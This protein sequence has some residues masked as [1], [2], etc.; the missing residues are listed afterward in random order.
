MKLFRPTTNDQ[1]ANALAHFFPS[2]CAWAAKNDKDANFRKFIEALAFEFKRVHDGMNDLSCDY[3]INMTTE[4]IDNWESAVGIPDHCFSKDVPIERRRLQV[5]VKFAKMN[6]QTA[7]DFARL[8]QLL[9]FTVTVKSGGDVGIFPLCF[10][11]VFFPDPTEARFTLILCLDKTSN[12]F[13]LD[14]PIQFSDSFSS[15]IVCILNVIKPA[16]VKLLVLFNC[17]TFCHHCFCQHCAP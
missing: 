10:P 11:I 6:V 2:G 3:D 1:Q 5:L 7:E 13:P 12:I 16:N 9:G 4:L 8:A 15:L 14:F 17:T